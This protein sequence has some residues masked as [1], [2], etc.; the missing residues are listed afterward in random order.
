MD[1]KKMKFTIPRIMLSC[2]LLIGAGTIS[3]QNVEANNYQDGVTALEAG[4]YETAMK[5][6]RTAAEDGHAGA[7]AAMG[8][9]YN[10]GRGT[11][12]NAQEAGK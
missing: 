6:F 1:T 10:R 12:R 9:L 8:E 11:E 4:D 5:R 2:C 7:Q 3:C